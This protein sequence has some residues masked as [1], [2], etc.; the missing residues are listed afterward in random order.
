M[1]SQDLFDYTLR[2]IKRVPW[3]LPTVAEA[4]KRFRVRQQDVLDAV[5]GVDPRDVGGDYFGYNV[6]IQCGSGYGEYDRIGEY[7]LEASVA[8]V[9]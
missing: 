1:T 5:E 4:A 8:E 6:G 3:E 7:T 9:P 2:R